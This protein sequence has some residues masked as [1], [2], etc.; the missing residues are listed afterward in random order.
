MQPFAFVEN[1]FQRFKVVMQNK[2]NAH[3]DGKMYKILNNTNNLSF[4]PILEL[5]HW[6]RIY[7]AY[8]ADALPLH[9]QLVHN[10][11][12]SS[13]QKSQFSNAQFSYFRITFMKLSPKH[14][15]TGLKK[16]WISKF[17][18]FSAQIPF[19]EGI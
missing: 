3:T 12:I 8:F 6:F 1:S 17:P 9:I 10:F 7:A 11:D 19:Y 2:L 14:N 5:V 15:Y 18:L 13:I 16:K 4:M